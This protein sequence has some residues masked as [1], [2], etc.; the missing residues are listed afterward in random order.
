M[1]TITKLP[2]LPTRDM[3][4]IVLSAVAVAATVVIGAGMWLIMS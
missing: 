4:T 2:V 3:G 1:S